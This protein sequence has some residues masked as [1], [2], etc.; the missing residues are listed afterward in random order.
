MNHLVHYHEK[1][2]NNIYVKM[3]QMWFDYYKNNSIMV[4]YLEMLDE[5]V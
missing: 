1:S 5:I 3:M 2:D 4:H